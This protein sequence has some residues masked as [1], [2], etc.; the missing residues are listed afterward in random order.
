MTDS[1]VKR[2]LQIINCNKN[3]LDA[4]REGYCDN[5]V[6]ARDLRFYENADL[7]NW[8]KFKEKYRGTTQ[9][10]Y[11][12]L[13][14]YEHAFGNNNKILTK[15]DF[16]SVPLFPL[17][18]SRDSALRYP[19]S[20]TVDVVDHYFGKAVKD[21]YRWL[22]NSSAP[23]S[24]KWIAEQDRLSR[25]IFSTFPAREK[26]VKRLRELYDINSVSMPVKKG[27]RYF[28]FKR[29]VGKQKPVYYYR[30]GSNGKEKVLIDPNKFDPR[31]NV[32]IGRTHPSHD[33][34]KVAYTLQPNNADEATLYVM[35]VASGKTSKIDVIEGARYAQP[36]W[37]PRND[38][39]YYTWVTTDP[40]I[41]PAERAGFMEVRFHKLGTD[42]KKNKT[43]FGRT[44]DPRKVISPQLSRD[45][46]WLVVSVS[47]T[48]NANEVYVR[49]TTKRG[50]E[51]KQ[52]F[53]SDQSIAN[54]IPWKGHFYV[55]ASDG[56]PNWRV[57]KVDVKHFERSNWKTIVPERKDT[58]LDRNMKIIGD[59]LVLI[60]EKNVVTELEVRTLDGHL[61][62]TVELPGIGTVGKVLGNPDD[63]EAYFSFESFTIPDRI[64]RTSIATGET[65]LWAQVNA[66]LDPSSYVVKQIFYPSKDGTRVPMFLIHRKD[67]PQDGST[68][69]ILHGY[70]GF[71]LSMTPWYMPWIYP[72]LEAG[73]AFAIAN[74]RGGGEYG[75]GWHKAGMKEKKQN[76]FDDF[77]AGAEHLIREGYTNP[78]KLAI[79]SQSNGG[80]LVGAA[81]V[82]RP[83]LFRAVVCGVPLLDMIRYHKFGIGKM[84]LA[85]YGSPDN[86]RDFGA[87]FAYSPYHNVKQGVPYPAVLFL[88]SE[89]DD[90]VDP[91][92]ARKMTAAMQN[93]S[94]SDHPVLLRI[95]K[96]AGHNG[97]DQI[98]TSI[99]QR[100]DMYSFL[101]SQLNVGKK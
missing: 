11:R 54:V 30:D 20:R 47:C 64:Y 60:V 72:W 68:P 39:F 87:L 75:E 51:F 32:S 67:M 17:Q 81:M 61:V 25:S 82:Q 21:P 45:G 78:E 43:I 16:R 93:S 80:L 23:E 100:A 22:E 42:P 83:D 84:W 94:A 89:S 71:G 85:E 35:D 95:Q 74:L 10:L 1:S 19:P 99:E 77:I 18:V 24:K 34:K 7:S 97:A 88:L 50:S 5:I 33:G 29:H 49:D 9:E 66:P 92:H 70:G 40:K 4:Q 48:R 31:R 28:Y 53:K 98:D 56:T 6:D 65:S 26:L 38:G 63:D 13:V 2:A 69:F 55:V 58:V 79:Y 37:T 41:Q 73:G 62:R 90:R 76:V 59:H 36:S 27:K 57:D 86:E 12:S 15:E 52:F 101:M 96:N 3:A 46:K 44:N 8:G 14:L 91:M